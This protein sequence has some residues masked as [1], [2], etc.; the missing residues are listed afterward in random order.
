M[1]TPF[2][3]FSEDANRYLDDDLQ[4]LVQ[5]LNPSDPKT[6]D[7]SASAIRRIIENAE[8]TK[9][10]HAKLVRPGL[11]RPGWEEAWREQQVVH[12]G[13]FGDIDRD[14]VARSLYNAFVAMIGFLLAD[15]PE[16]RSQSAD[17]LQKR[18]RSYLARRKRELPKASRPPGGSPS[19]A[20]GKYVFYK[21]DE[22]GQWV[23]RFGDE[24]GEFP[25][26]D[27]KAMSQ[28]Q[29]LLSKAGQ[30]VS[31]TELNHHASGGPPAEHNLR[32]AKGEAAAEL[33]QTEGYQHE[34]AFEP[35]L[36]RTGK[37]IYRTEYQSAMEDLENA[38]KNN[39]PG[40]AEKAQ[41]KLQAIAEAKGLSC[42]LY[43]RPRPLGGR[44][45]SEKD[46]NTVQVSIRRIKEKIREKLPR[47]AAHLDRTI[48]PEKGSFAYLP[49]YD[50][51]HQP[52]PDWQF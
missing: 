2:H 52:P 1:G 6:Y 29:A 50:L 39:D 14:K 12:T 31:A 42:G 41:R 49:E 24:S 20:C 7:E 44:R 26:K 21:D 15:T 9:D 8:G 10:A 38:R 45:P 47:L 23:I 34:N 13:W 33:C 4:V 19:L 25:I 40:A 22:R 18:L 30:R 17:S 51:D 37:D 11:L 27:N 43:G 28:L 46:Y 36:D 5:T 48:D 35:T 3:F 16:D 32:R